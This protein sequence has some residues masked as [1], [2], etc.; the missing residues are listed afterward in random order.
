MMEPER[1]QKIKLKR[2]DPSKRVSSANRNINT[3]PQNENIS[4]LKQ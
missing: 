3:L 1:L 2:K 4:A